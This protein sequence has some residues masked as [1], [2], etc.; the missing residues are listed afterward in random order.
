M[1]VTFHH[2]QAARIIKEAEESKVVVKYNAQIR[3][4]K[5]QLA[6]CLRSSTEI[7]AWGNPTV[8]SREWTP[9]ISKIEKVDPPPGANGELQGEQ[10]KTVAYAGCVRQECTRRW[11]SDCP[12]LLI[13]LVLNASLEVTPLNCPSTTSEARMI[14]MKAIE[15]QHSIWMKEALVAVQSLVDQYADNG[16][17]QK[18]AEL[19]KWCDPKQLA[20]HH[21]NLK[22][23]LGSRL[24][25]SAPRHGVR[26]SKGPWPR[27]LHRF[28]DQHLK[29]MEEARQKILKSTTTASR[30][31]EQVPTGVDR[32][33]CSIKHALFTSVLCAEL[34]CEAHGALRLVPF[35]TTLQ[36]TRLFGHVRLFKA[37]ACAYHGVAPFAILAKLQLSL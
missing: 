23:I 34:A 29:D 4:L 24:C 26:S 28:G 13:Y 12:F 15:D 3:Q 10:C 27:V 17:P 31:I 6:P 37:R 32:P 19:A 16:F 21:E 25:F 7:I 30:G 11:V 36:V 20:N 33:D 8:T 14:E 5:F 35:S 18:G 1:P 22:V 9:G 2:L